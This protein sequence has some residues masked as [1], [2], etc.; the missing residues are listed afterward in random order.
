M[1]SRNWEIVGRVNLLGLA[2]FAR[3]TSLPGNLNWHACQVTRTLSL[4]VPEKGGRFLGGGLMYYRCIEYLQPAGL[5]PD[6]VP[7]TLAI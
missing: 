4:H 1:L 7:S 3:L 2:L 6:G 5:M